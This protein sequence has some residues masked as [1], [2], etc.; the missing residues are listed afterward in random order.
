MLKNRETSEYHIRLFY[1]TVFNREK[2]TR[3]HSGFRY[4]SILIV[5]STAVGVLF[6]S[7]S[8]VD[9]KDRTSR[10]WHNNTRTHTHTRTRARTR[11]EREQDRTG[12]CASAR[13]RASPRE[14]ERQRERERLSVE[15]GCVFV[16]TV[17]IHLPWS[18]VTQGSPNALC[19]LTVFNFVLTIFPWRRLARLRLYTKKQC[20]LCLTDFNPFL[21][22]HRWFMFFYTA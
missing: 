7:T 12:G 22:I 1:A 19:S 13:N 18:L 16:W 15:C 20:A 9:L 3:D 21:Q 8:D 11:A 17:W 2:L 6:F 5:S 10:E 4:S 14:S